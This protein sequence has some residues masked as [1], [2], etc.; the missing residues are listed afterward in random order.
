LLILPPEKTKKMIIDF[1]AHIYPEKIAEKASK[2]IADFYNTSMAFDGS[3]ENLLKSGATIDVKKYIVHST[4]T[5]PE[6]VIHINDYIISQCLKHDCFVGF[7][8]LHPDFQDNISEIDRILLAGIRGIKLHPDFQKFQFD[9]NKMDDVYKYLSEKNMPIL[10]HAGDYRYDFSSPK[11]IAAVIEKFPDLK[12]VAAH[13]GGY[14]EWDK[15][16]EY[17]VGKRVWFDTSSTLWKLDYS[18]ANKMLKAHGVEKFFFGTDYPMWNHKEELQR[19][20]K[21][22][23]T[24]QEQEMILWKNAA[25]FLNLTLE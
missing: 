3:V 14:S 19:F 7:G 13:F 25:E 15:S 1:H 17:L 8:T 2:S 9:S 21:L 12:I 18:T 20:L 23:L 11:R 16:V 22:D 5:K 4:A 10:V 24:P 6:Q